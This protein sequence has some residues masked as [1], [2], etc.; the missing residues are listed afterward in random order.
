MTL[1]TIETDGY[2]ITTDKS[3][4]SIHDIHKWLSERSYWCKNVPF[5]IVKTSFDHSFCIGVLKD[6]KQVG[7]A[8]L[9][10]DY[11]TFGYLADVY[12]LEEHRGKGL[13]KA[14]MKAI[15]SLDWVKNLRGIKLQ[16]KDG[17]GLYAQF[18]FTETKFPDRIM[19]ISR[20]NIYELNVV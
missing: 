1:I 6:G 12:V 16:T 15:M 10:T 11:A 4:M 19:E 18:G 13:S 5:D 9:I 7:F 3:R 17:H 2:I 20:P 8:R 14:M